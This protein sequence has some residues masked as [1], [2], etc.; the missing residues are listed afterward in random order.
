ME[1]QPFRTKPPGRCQGRGPTYRR[2]HF[3][4]ASRV[5]VSLAVGISRS[6]RISAGQ[7]RPRGCAW[8]R[9]G[10]GRLIFVIRVR[11]RSP[12]SSPPSTQFV[13]QA[14]PNERNF[15]RVNSMNPARWMIP[16]L[17]PPREL[18]PACPVLT[19]G[20]H[21]HPPAALSSPLVRERPRHERLR[22]GQVSPL[23]FCFKTTPQPSMK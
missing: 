22:R 7:A 6:G 19:I 2:P 21:F 20:A 10:G 13:G 18:G 12:R 17:P 3:P 11:V 4:G 15:I 9:S 14:G 23:H 16:G 8:K 5:F 1:A